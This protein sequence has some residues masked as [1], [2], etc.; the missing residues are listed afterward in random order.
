MLIFAA[1]GIAN[2]QPDYVTTVC[3]RWQQPSVKWSA[4]AIPVGVTEKELH[5][6]LGTL[7][8]QL[9]EKRVDVSYGYYAAQNASRDPRAIGRLWIDDVPIESLLAMDLSTQ[10]RTCSISADM[11][12]KAGLIAGEKRLA[13][14]EERLMKAN[15][16][17]LSVAKSTGS[18][19]AKANKTS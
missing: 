1:F 7:T 14:A 19:T 3:V 13:A 17:K 10:G 12:V 2:D 4:S 5:K 15:E 6:A 11:I 16:V 18:K 8:R 9:A